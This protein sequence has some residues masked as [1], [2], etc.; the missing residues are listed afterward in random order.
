MGLRDEVGT[1]FFELISDKENLAGMSM[2][3]IVSAIVCFIVF[4][5]WPLRYG[6]LYKP[7][8]SLLH[9]EIS[10]KAAT[11]IINLAGTIP[12]LFLFL[13]A[14]VPGFNILAPVLYILIH[15]YKGTY[16]AYKRSKFATPFPLEVVIYRT[17]VEFYCGFIAMCAFARAKNYPLGVRDVIKAF[18]FV[19]LAGYQGYLDLQ[20]AKLRY[21][22]DKGYKAVTWFPFNLVTSPQYFLEILIWVVWFTFLRF[23]ITTVAHL[24]WLMPNVVLRAERIHRWT[25]N[26]Q[27]V[28]HSKR[29]SMIPYFNISSLMEPLVAFFS[30]GGL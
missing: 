9:K 22:G 7:G 26:F 19:G 21:K 2:F 27:K 23:K 6:R 1:L 3:G 25:N 28:K 14:Y 11:S 5:K 16:Y 15:L 30:T 18:V 12:F 13:V 20:L 24:I 10:S 8:T 29:T 17:L 4:L